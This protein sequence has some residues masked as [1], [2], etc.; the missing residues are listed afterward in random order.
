MTH[1]EYCID[2]CKAKCCSIY[3]GP[4]KVNCP[5]LIDSRC[6]VYKERFKEGAEAKEIVGFVQI[7]G[8]IQPFICGRI[9]DLISE[10]ALPGWIEAQCCYAHPELLKGDVCSE[11][12]R[13]E[14][15]TG[16]LT[17]QAITARF[18][19]TSWSF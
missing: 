5:K 3:H 13:L 19:R 16:W 12:Q 1:D 10:K 15:S 8:N 9:L 14:T 17:E 11:N 7:G 2:V 4:E 18:R 6:S